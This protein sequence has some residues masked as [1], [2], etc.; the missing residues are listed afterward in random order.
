MKF[1]HND[2]QTRRQIDPH[3]VGSSKKVLAM[4]DSDMQAQVLAV[5]R[6]DPVQ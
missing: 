4:L 1:S 5:I 2:G 6:G 3:Y